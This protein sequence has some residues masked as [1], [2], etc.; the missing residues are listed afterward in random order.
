M[1]DTLEAVHVI[2]AHKSDGLAIAIGTGGTTDT[3]YVIL[4]I[5]RHIVVDNQSD[6]VDIDTTGHN[7]GSHQHIGL[8]G[9]KTIHSLIALGLREVGVHLVAVNVHRL[10]LAGN[11]LYTLFLTREDNHA[12]QVAFLKDV[13]NNLQLLWLIAH[14]SHL[15][16]LLGGL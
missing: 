15:V 12:L 2:V 7:I 5:R 11:L 9:L 1:L 16:N 14:V 4:A 6:I 10:Q 13:L 3:V 8:S